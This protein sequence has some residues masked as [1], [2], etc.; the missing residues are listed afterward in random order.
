MAIR[1]AAVYAI[2]E[3][4]KM[5]WQWICYRVPLPRLRMNYV[6]ICDIA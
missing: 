4:L 5:N 3:Q 6:L 1:V 2:T